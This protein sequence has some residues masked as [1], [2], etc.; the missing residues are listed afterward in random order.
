MERDFR[1]IIGLVAA[2]AILAVGG[3]VLLRVIVPM[4]LESRIYGAVGIASLVGLGGVLGICW[5][6]FHTAKHFIQKLNGETQ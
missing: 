5:V 2:G 4:I 1:I 3:V 6:A